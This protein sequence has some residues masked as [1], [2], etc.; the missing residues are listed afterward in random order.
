M[1]EAT[2]DTTLSITRI[3]K[4]PREKVFRAWVEPEQM[5][6]WMAP[7]PIVVEDVAVDLKVGGAYRIVMNDKSRSK[8]H[9]AVGVY[10]EIT[11]PERLVC[12]W[13]WEGEEPAVE[14]LVTVT[15]KD[16]GATTEMHILHE[17][18]PDAESRDGHTEGWNACFEKLDTVLAG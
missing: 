12:T 10:K 11:S 5:R 7:G 9:I 6:L 8:K 4:A 1:P 13:M 17:L 14:T 2:T 15:F 18:F 16:M 3:I